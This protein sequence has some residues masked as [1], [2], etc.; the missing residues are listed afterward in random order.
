MT[1]LRGIARSLWIYYRDPSQWRRMRAL[2]AQFLQR[3]DLA[4]DIGAHVGSRTRA[5][6]ALGARVIAVEPVPAAIRV[7]RLLYGWHPRVEVVQAAVGATPGQMSMLVSEREPTVST[8]SA[9]WAARM[10]RER[11]AFAR[12]RW[13]RSV[14]V[15]VT[16]L[17]ELIGRFGVPAFCKIDVEGYDVQVLEGL[18]QPL[19]ALSFEYVPPAL[20]LALACLE[21]VDR[22]GS[23]EYNW[24]LGDSM[25]LEWPDWV[26]R[27]RLAAHL[28]TL[29]RQGTPGDVYARRLQ[30]GS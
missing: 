23:Y 16:T 6:A 5:Y 2:Y 29:P 19:P 3:G 13:G 15:P 17:D 14:I 26:S 28:A 1:Q 10:R 22:L 9:E 7:L 4:F 18:S 11:H 12:T 20:D 30:P 25:R 21:R 27:E 24:S 8:L